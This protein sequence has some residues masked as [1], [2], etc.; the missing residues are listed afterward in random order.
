MEDNVKGEENNDVENEDVEEEEDDDVEVDDVQEEDR[1]T[2]VILCEHVQIEF[3]APNVGRTFFPQ[4]AQSKCTW[5]K[6]RSHFM[7]KL[8][9][10]CRA[11]E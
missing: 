3:P 2:R 9:G 5:T 1:S 7:R 8:Q 4:R 6:R 11:P 10:K